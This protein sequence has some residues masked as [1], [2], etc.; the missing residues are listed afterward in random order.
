MDIQGFNAIRAISLLVFSCNI[1][2]IPIKDE[3]IRK[4]YNLKSVKSRGDWIN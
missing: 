4:I 3:E 2:N 1:T